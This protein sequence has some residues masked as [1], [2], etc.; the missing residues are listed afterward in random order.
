MRRTLHAAVAVALAATFGA[1]ATRAQPRVESEI[2]PDLDLYVTSIDAPRGEP[3]FLTQSALAGGARLGSTMTPGAAPSASWLGEGD[4]DLLFGWTRGQ[5]TLVQHRSR[6][7]LVLDLQPGFEAAP[8]FATVRGRHELYARHGA[9]G[10][11]TTPIAERSPRSPSEIWSSVHLPD[12]F[13][14]NAFGADLE[15]AARVDH[16][17]AGEGVLRFD[18]GRGRFAALALQAGVWLRKSY[19]DEQAM[20]MPLRLSYA[21]TFA[22]LE[23]G[24]GVDHARASVGADTGF[25]FKHYFGYHYHGW[26]EALGLGWD[27]II[28]AVGP[29]AD[30]IELR[31]LHLDDVVFRDRFWVFGP[32]CVLFGRAFVGAHW[33]GAEAGA[34]T[35]ALPIFAAALGARFPLEAARAELTLGGAR[36]AD[37]S[38]R[39]G[40]F[41]DRYRVES[42]AAVVMEPQGIGG[43]TTLTSGWQRDIEADGDFGRQLGIGSSLW[44][45]FVDDFLGFGLYHR[46]QTGAPLDADAFAL[47]DGWRH[48]VGLFVRSRAAVRS[49]E[50]YPEGPAGFSPW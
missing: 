8:V 39:S 23:P 5:T 48:D 28:A 33:L 16:G 42:R 17:R 10:F 43:E 44:I 24:S 30:R 18:V 29:A 25:G 37:T 50:R 1:R 46:A 12:H 47:A 41:V 36:E 14:P 3:R 15:L 21:A 6:A 31:A 13:A 27:R 2:L 34:R 26:L 40:R 11:V 45:D 7:A 22:E 38:L 4:I 9:G 20:V 35:A 19:D 49:G 32:R